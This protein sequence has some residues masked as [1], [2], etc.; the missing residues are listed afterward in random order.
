MDTTILIIEDDPIAA[1]LLQLILGRQGYRSLI[2]FDGL[3]GLKIA[4]SEQVDLILLDLMLP[5]I[6]G[7]EVLTQLR[8]DPK[9]ADLL[10]M[11]VSVKSQTTDRRAAA[12]LGADAYLTKPYTAKEIVAKVNSLLHGEAEKVTDEAPCVMLIGTHRQDAARTALYTGLALNNKGVRVTLIDLYPLSTDYSVLLGLPPRQTS[13]L[14]ADPGTTRQLTDLIERHSSGL[15][16]LN[17]LQ[18]RGQSGQL[19]FKDISSLLEALPSQGSFVLA[20][21]PLD[22]P[23]EVMCQLARYCALV[24]LITRDDPASMQKARAALTLMEREDIAKQSIVVMIVGPATSGTLPAF[25]Q[26]GIHVIHAETTANHPVFYDLAAR[27]REA[28][29]PSH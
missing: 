9:T 29:K 21:L 16:L 14:L 26:E 15:G 8:A 18:G 10:V 6:D 7:F 19:T 24:L 27:A 20:D 13:I 4:R 28:A 3:E 1:N 11:I 2:A 12:K 22:Y 17:N 25:E 23:T 5:G